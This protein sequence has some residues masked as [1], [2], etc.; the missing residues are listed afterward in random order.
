MA[1]SIFKRGATKTFTSSWNDRRSH[2]NTFAIPNAQASRSIKPVSQHAG[3]SSE[4]QLSFPIFAR[5]KRSSSIK[6][7]S[8]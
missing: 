2:I 5:A 3:G 4:Q 8:T 7:I 6:F 1:A